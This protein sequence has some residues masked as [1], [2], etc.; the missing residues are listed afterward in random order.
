MKITIITINKDNCPGLRQT[1]ESVVRQTYFHTIE[2]VVV[3]GGSIDGSREL[4]DDYD[5]KLDYWVSEPD[6]GIYNAMNKGVAHATGDYVLFLNSGDYLSSDDVIERVQAVI[7]NASVHEDVF[8]I[9]SVNCVTESGVVTGTHSY[10]ASVQSLW[11]FLCKVIP[12]QSAFIPRRLLAECPYD[13]S[14][15]ISA[16]FKFFMEMLQ[17]RMKPVV[18]LDFVVSN[19]DVTGISSVETRKSIE[20]RHRAFLETLPPNIAADYKRV[21]P[22]KEYRYR[23]KWLLSHPFLVKIIRLIT[24]IGM[25]LGL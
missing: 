16:D 23:I 8:F 6:K 10:D 20:E 7:S 15:K 25:R 2:Y 4:L 22:Y 3:D 13:E 9:G 14:Y 5:Q 17:I 12:H 11:D 18:T 21:L 1:L 19:Y 24:S